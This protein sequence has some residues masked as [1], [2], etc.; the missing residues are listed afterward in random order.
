M[1][2]Y[3]LVSGSTTG[4]EKPVIGAESNY[5]ANALNDFQ[6]E[7]KVASTTMNPLAL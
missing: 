1:S 5:N 4:L 3:S 6:S 2:L 7:L